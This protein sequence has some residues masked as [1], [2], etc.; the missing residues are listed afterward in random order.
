[1]TQTPRDDNKKD[2]LSQG[3][4]EIDPEVLNKLLSQIPDGPLKNVEEVIFP[5]P[6]PHFR[7]PR[8]LKNS[9]SKR[10]PKSIEDWNKEVRSVWGHLYDTEE[11]EKS[12]LAQLPTIQKLA[13]SEHG[14]RT[15]GSGLAL[16]A[17]LK[18]ALEE[19]LKYDMEDKTKAVL[20]Y[21]PKM[22]I[23]DIASQV[24]LERSSLSRR[25]VSRAVNL[26]TVAF[27]RLTDRST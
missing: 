22:K 19:V 8:R 4:V 12:W 23:I 9:K 10:G 14:G 13:A 17:L 11:L 18:K 3:D 24:G 16:Q 1:M 5:E 27:Q 7:I 25:Y 6:L 26:L 2:N 15:I 21:F 20:T